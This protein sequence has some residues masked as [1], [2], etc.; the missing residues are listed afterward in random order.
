MCFVGG[1]YSKIG[2]PC[3]LGALCGSLIETRIMVRQHYGIAQDCTTDFGCGADC[4][5]AWCCSVCAA[6]QMDI[7]LDKMAEEGAPMN[8]SPK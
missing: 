1:L 3:C 2:M 6:L 4:A 5:A 8:G 7:H